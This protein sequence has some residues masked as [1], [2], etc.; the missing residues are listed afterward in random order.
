[1]SAKKQSKKEVKEFYVKQFENEFKRGDFL[2]E[3]YDLVK[4][5]VYGPGTRDSLIAVDWTGVFQRNSCPACSGSITLSNEN[6]GCGQCEFR[7]PI[8]K[9]EDASKKYD[10][11]VK[12]LDKQKK[13]AAKVLE[14][15]MSKKEL[16]E[17]IMKA[18]ETALKKLED[19][20]K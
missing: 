12:D 5:T 17:L 18:S 7:I 10:T 9:F 15:G 8:Q 14:S 13:Y 19:K 2:A 4:T 11:M 1:M 20:K 16:R 6:Y 3:I